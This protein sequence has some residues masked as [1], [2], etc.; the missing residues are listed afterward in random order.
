MLDKG[1]Q[2][3]WFSSY[4]IRT[5]LT[6]A[7][8]GGAAFVARELIARHPVVNLRILKERTFSA[9]VLLITSVMFVLYGSMVLIPIWLQTLL[10]YPALQAGFALAPRGLGSFIAMPIVG[11]LIPKVDARRLLVLGMLTCA[12]T[13]F[14]ISRLSLD[15]GYWDF[16][17][18]QFF[19]GVSLSMLF[20]PITTVT[21]GP[22]AR[23]QMGNA[24]SLYSLMRN[25]G[26]SFGIATVTTYVARREQIHTHHLVAHLS[27]YIPQANAM[28][29]NMQRM[30]EGRGSGPVTSVQQGY[31]QMWGMVERQAAILSYLDAFVLLAGLFVVL[32]PLIFL[33]KK[34]PKTTAAAS[35]AAAH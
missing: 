22:I 28:L 20:V 18:P 19:Q 21:M 10:G 8:V 13:M 11:I 35:A 3:D 17:W 12:V 23:E 33:M 32:V 27:P 6:L 34:P 5:L 29:N 26:A 1:Q 7:I 30:M 25:L 31:L 14:A 15:A 24:A 2:E 16:F 9:G 4:F